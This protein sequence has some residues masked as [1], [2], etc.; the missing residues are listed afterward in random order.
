MRKHLVVLSVFLTILNEGWTQQ[1]QLFIKGSGQDLHIDHKVSPKEGIFAIGRLYNV[2]PKTIANYNKLDMARGLL[3]GQVIHIPL[4]DTNFSQ[5]ASKGIPVYYTVGDKET[6]QKVSNVNNKVPLQNLRDWNKLQND[7]LA[8]GSKL[9]VGFL[10]TGENSTAATTSQKKDE[11]VKEKKDEPGKETVAKQNSPKTDE[12]KPVVKNDPPK[13][14]PKKSEPVVTKSQSSPTTAVNIQG[15][16]KNDFDQQVRK[17]PVS[18]SE[19]VTSG[20]FK[21][22]SKAQE[23]KYYLLID[24][25]TPGTIVRVTN[26]D[27]NKAVYAKVLGGMSGIRQNQGFDIRISNTAAATLGITDTDKFIVLLNY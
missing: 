21:M 13:E 24:R 15:Y 26:P 22:N 2:H 14:E 23:V 1:G 20:I 3:V 8:A 11:P 19:T 12:D 4:T 9:I 18:R 10:L 7:N 27:N 17:T 6:I 16:F 25:V 5:V